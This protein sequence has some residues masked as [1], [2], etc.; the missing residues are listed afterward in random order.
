MASI[1]QQGPQ[2]ERPQ[3]YGPSYQ[4]DEP[5]DPQIPRHYPD[6]FEPHVAPAPPP[7][8]LP[9]GHPGGQARSRSATRTSD[10]KQRLRKACDSCSCDESGPP[11][12]SCAALDIPCTF[13]RPSRRRGPPNRHAEAIKRQKL[14]NGGAASTG[15]PTHDA[16]WG[17]AA[18]S[19]PATLS[20][21]SICDLDT[22]DILINDYFIYIHPLIPVPHEPS[23]R[24][25]F[26]RREDKTDRIFLG[27]I[28]AM[29]ETLV[30]SFP[31][32]AR[33]LFASEQAKHQYPNAGALID[34][35]HAIFIEARGIGYLDREPSVN[36]AISS[37]LAGISASYLFDVRRTRMYWGEC[38]MM[39]RSMGFYRPGSMA[40]EQQGPVS[41]DHIRQ[42]S[43]RRV[44]WLLFVGAMSSRQLDE[45]EGDLLMPPIASSERLPSLPAEVDDQYV[46]QETIFPQQ[47]GVV[48][49]LVGFNL[50]CQIY[51][52]FHRLAAIEAVF[53]ADTVYDWDR[54][55]LVIR[56][57]L[58]TV[59]AAIADAP[60]ELQ[61]NTA[62]E[63]GEW[64]PR[65]YDASVYSMQ[66]SVVSG[67]YPHPDGRRDSLALTLP[68]SRRAIQCEIQK[69]NI[70]G[71]LLATRSYLVERY[72]NLFEIH[73]QERTNQPTHAEPLSSIPSM[74]S[75]TLIATDPRFAASIGLTQ[76]PS[77][78][79]MDAIEQSM[80]V[81]RE[82]IVR[83]LALLLKSV[84][85]VNMEP[86]GLSFCN[87]IRQVASTLLE[88]KKSYRNVM[89]TLNSSRVN[90]YLLDFLEILSKL[91]RLGA[92]GRIRPDEAGAYGVG[93]S[94]EAIEE[95]ELVQWAS[96]KEHQ[97][98]FL[99][100]EQIMLV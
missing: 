62:S 38:V 49:E 59:K 29:V 1:N 11:C 85:Q 89:P 40:S 30:V 36:E 52:A 26:A 65:S 32:R 54:Q 15:S 72:W 66:S 77:D 34:H 3:G 56:R 42:Q 22:L 33:R 71:S 73:E 20:A 63:F 99:H 64:P 13:E 6:P 19:L 75:P 100:S 47:E 28:A 21:E 55:K 69:A 87:K 2:Y 46:T 41:V 5:I 9:Q 44:F 82:N 79:A 80:A 70:Y 51:R 24:A 97:E 67:Q 18:L 31:R 7:H 91:Q 68:F 12:K 50:N 74:S 27:M 94:P 57:A 53:G 92:A 37:Y 14:E 98:R 35:C 43:G 23:F 8:H 81:E 86:N 83:D 48:S 39:I 17:L 90:E 93:K 10:L 76:S 95:E 60:K 96:L 45:A 61:L 84:N 25:A 78:T 16:A 88:T 58:Q 4:Y